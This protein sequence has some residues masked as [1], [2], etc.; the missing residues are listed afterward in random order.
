MNALSPWAV[1]VKN[2]FHGEAR[3]PSILFTSTIN[4]IFTL[5]RSNTAL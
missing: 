3:S 2:L 1:A 4:R 5:M